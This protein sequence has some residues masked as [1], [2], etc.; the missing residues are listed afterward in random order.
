[1]NEPARRRDQSRRLHAHPSRRGGESQADS[2]F[3]DGMVLVHIAIPRTISSPS[4][5]EC[6]LE[7]AF[8]LGVARVL[9]A[10]VVAMY[11]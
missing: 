3:T 11:R 7:K 10:R 1:M 9:S 8:E 4:R 6:S 2:L 5:R